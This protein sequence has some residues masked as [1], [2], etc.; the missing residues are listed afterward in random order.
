MGII[1]Y[2]KMNE[3]AVVEQWEKYI[4]DNYP[5]DSSKFLIGNKNQF[6]NPIGYTI[7]TEIPVIFKAILNNEF[8][9]NFVNSLENFIRIRAIQN[10]SVEEA[11][12]FLKYVKVLIE[13]YVKTNFNS[14]IFDEY[15]EL[16]GRLEKVLHKSFESYL[17]M[18]QKLMEIKLDEVKRKN[19][20]MVDRLSKKYGIEEDE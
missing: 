4:I 14:E 3:S 12:S 8:D 1:E 13:N 11:N 15:L 7:R 17:K 6:D 18:K 16:N 5:K 2:L 10:Y 19:Q 20:R 9:D